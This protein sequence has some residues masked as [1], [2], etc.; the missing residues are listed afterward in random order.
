MGP[1]K[2]QEAKNLEKPWFCQFLPNTAPG[3]AQAA[4]SGGSEEP[5]KARSGLGAAQEPPKNHPRATQEPLR[6]AQEPPK[7][8]QDGP[9]GATT[10]PG[11]AKRAQGSSP[12]AFPSLENPSKTLQKLIMFCKV[13]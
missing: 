5:S 4:P 7:T 6:T 9:R 2:P 8:T 1:K 10:A 12:E 13:S 11:A 3:E